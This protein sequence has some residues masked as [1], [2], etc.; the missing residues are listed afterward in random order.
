MRQPGKAG[1]SKG[2]SGGSTSAESLHV[3]AGSGR[4]GPRWVRGD[5]RA[6]REQMS[7]EGRMGGCH[8]VGSHQRTETVVEAPASSVWRMPTPAGR[9]GQAE[10]ELAAAVREAVTA[11]LL[12]DWPRGLGALG[13]TRT[14]ATAR[15]SVR[16]HGRGAPAS[17]NG[18]SRNGEGG[19][20]SSP[21]PGQCQCA[22]VTGFHPADSSSQ[23]H[24]AVAGGAG[25]AGRAV[26]PDDP[27]LPR[28]VSRVSHRAADRC[29]VSRAKLRPRTIRRHRPAC[30][31]A[32]RHVNGR[33]DQ[34]W[35]PNWLRAPRHPT[36]QSAV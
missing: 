6:K 20:K 34:A 18:G 1:E 22:I 16:R 29:G 23:P 7:A 15:A 26:Q 32:P 25:P 19:T 2:C 10:T 35:R 13:P 9:V 4:Q 3:P 14:S 27:E 30:L 12:H 36:G 31:G 21:R 11:V 5:G 33:M 28:P 24:R 8:M 17:S